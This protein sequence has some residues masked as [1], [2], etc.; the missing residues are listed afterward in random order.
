V[1]ILNHTGAGGK[2][3]SYSGLPEK[4]LIFRVLVLAPQKNYLQ[5]ISPFPPLFHYVYLSLL[6]VRNVSGGFSVLS[7]LWA[8]KELLT[9]PSE[10]ELPL[11]DS[12]KSR[13]QSF[14]CS[15]YESQRILLVPAKFFSVKTSSGAFC[16]LGSA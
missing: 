13:N 4:L 11:I 3:S 14:F 12:W 8:F 5:S 7:V 9:N 6:V 1:S 15:A 10:L 16:F 2:L